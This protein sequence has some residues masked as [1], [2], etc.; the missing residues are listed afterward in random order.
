M[1][2]QSP[3]RRRA[4]ARW[5]PIKPAPPV[6]KIR[7]EPIYTSPVEPIIG[8]IGVLFPPKNNIWGWSRNHSNTNTKGMITKPQKAPAERTGCS[9]KLVVRH[10]S[11]AA[12]V[13]NRILVNAFV[14]PSQ[15]FPVLFCCKLLLG[16]SP[17]CCTQIGLLQQSQ[18]L[19]AEGV[20]I[21]RLKNQAG[22][23]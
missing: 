14:P 23:L 11:S 12:C 22:A 19:R 15:H 8:Q 20:H 1:K 2:S 17:Q 6:S 10:G 9:S 3:R 21:A 4:S 5:D 13:L 16:S 18:R 7:S